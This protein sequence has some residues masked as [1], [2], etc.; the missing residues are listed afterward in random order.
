MAFGVSKSMVK[1]DNKCKKGKWNRILYDEVGIVSFKHAV[2]NCEEEC[3]SKCGKE[4][5]DCFGDENILPL[6]FGF[7]FDGGD[8]LVESKESDVE[9]EKECPD[10]NPKHFQKVS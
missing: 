10:G 8:Y 5:V 7:V 3:K 9:Y 6:Y 1:G 2:D 4:K